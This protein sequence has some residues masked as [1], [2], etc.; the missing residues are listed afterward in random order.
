VSYCTHGVHISENCRA[1]NEGR[2]AVPVAMTSP[3]AA[4]LE[5]VIRRIKSDNESVGD[6]PRPSSTYIEGWDAAFRIIL[7][8]DRLSA[9]ATPSAGGNEA[10]LE[11]RIRDLRLTLSS[12]ETLAFSAPVEWKTQR[13]IGNEAKRRLDLDN[14]AA[15][16]APP[17]SNGVEADKPFLSEEEKSLF[18]QLEDYAK[19]NNSDFGKVTIYSSHLLQLIWK[20]QEAEAILTRSGSVTDGWR[21]ITDKQRDGSMMWVSNGSM[22]R[23]AFWAPGKQYEHQGSV[24][25]G[26]RDFYSNRA[27]GND[28]Q[29][30]PTLWH[31]LP[32]KPLPAAPNAGGK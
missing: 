26:W 3:H 30:L 29:W 9:L 6:E 18:G 12:I 19:A 15:K 32:P 4:R 31:P 23:V 17:A 25:G 22:M 2:P 28:L 24:G 10:L 13:T 11:Q 27:A 14:E 7:E 1:C 20:I 21:T 5:A 16:S 8:D